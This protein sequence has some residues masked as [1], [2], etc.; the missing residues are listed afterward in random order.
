MSLVENRPSLSDVS[1]RVD[2][3]AQS[4]N[5]LVAILNILEL[6]KVHGGRQTWTDDHAQALR[7]MIS[8]CDRLA[9]GSEQKHSIKSV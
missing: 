3:Q 1:T 5:R 7:T 9:E 4:N 8:I 2:L 6:T